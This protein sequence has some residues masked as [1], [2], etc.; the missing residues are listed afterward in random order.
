MSKGRFFTS[1]RTTM[2]F[3]IFEFG[4]EIAAGAS[5]DYGFLPSQE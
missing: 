4:F 2:G 3:S 1:F 5:I